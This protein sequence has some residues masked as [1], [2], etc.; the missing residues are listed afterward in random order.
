MWDVTDK[1]IDRFALTA[2]ANWGLL[3][4][5]GISPLNDRVGLAQAV[6]NARSSCIL[7]FAIGASPVIWGIP[8]DLE[9]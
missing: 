4:I 5:P 7:Q 8:S 6:A 9:F 2:L 1:D 3:D